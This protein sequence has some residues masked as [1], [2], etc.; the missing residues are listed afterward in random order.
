MEQVDTVASMKKAEFLNHSCIVLLI[1]G[2][3]QL[4]LFKSKVTQENNIYF[5]QGN[6]SDLFLKGEEGSH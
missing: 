2:A 6:H 1:W 3:M 5:F 4:L